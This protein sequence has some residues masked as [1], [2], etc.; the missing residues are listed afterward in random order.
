MQVIQQPLQNPTYLQQLY[1]AQGQL[2]MPLHPSLNPQ[3]IQV[4]IY[5]ENPFFFVAQ[6]IFFR[7]GISWKF[8][9][10]NVKLEFAKGMDL[11]SCTNRTK[12]L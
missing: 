10:V 8:F 3:Q 9:F 1:N 2:L 5:Y 11:G 12:F 4:N 7:R 6:Y